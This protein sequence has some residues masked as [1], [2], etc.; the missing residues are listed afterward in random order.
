MSHGQSKRASHKGR[1]QRADRPDRDGASLATGYRRTYRT[2]PGSPRPRGSEP[3]SQGRMAVAPHLHAQVSGGWRVARAAN[4]HS[5]E[6]EKLPGNKLAG[7]RATTE[8]VIRTVIQAGGIAM[9]SQL[10]I[11][12]RNIKRSEE[13]E[14]WIRSEAAKIETF[15]SQLIGCR[16]AVEVPHRHH[17]KGSPYH[18][19]IDLT[20]PRGE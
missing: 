15:Y 8:V 11:T 20:V 14:G 10:Q 17:R 3:A 6:I 7:E 5:R 1:R 13:I 9:K 12:F 19:R 4:G 18:I 16:V 2:Q